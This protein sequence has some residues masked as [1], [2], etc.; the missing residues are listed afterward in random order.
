[1]KN[2]ISQILAAPELPKRFWMHRTRWQ[3]GIEQGKAGLGLAS[4]IRLLQEMGYT[5][6]IIV[7]DPFGEIV[8]T[9][10]EG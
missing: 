8:A 6:E 4:K 7:R 1:M 10:N 5:V 9:Q 2:L 3:R